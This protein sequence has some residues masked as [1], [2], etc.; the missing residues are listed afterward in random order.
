MPLAH[1]SCQALVYGSCGVLTAIA[2][3]VFDIDLFL[4]TFVMEVCM[5]LF[6]NVTVLIP[7]QVLS[8]Q[9]DG[10]CNANN[11][12]VSRETPM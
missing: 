5:L 12:R 11:V 8:G 3:E 9:Y 2:G 7:C 1:H 10:L 4:R 6:Y